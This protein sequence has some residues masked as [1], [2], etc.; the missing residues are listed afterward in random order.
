MDDLGSI[1]N[2]DFLK[3]KEKLL[4][5]FKMQ[6]GIDTPPEE[7]KKFLSLSQEKL[8]ELAT[9]EPVPEIFNCPTCNDGKRIRLTN[10]RKEPYFG[11]TF[12]CPECTPEDLLIRATGVDKAYSSWNLDQL[13]MDR[14]N[15]DDAIERLTAGDSLVMYG[16]V[17]RGK[18]HMAIGLLR[19]W[20]KLGGVTA[21]KYKPARFIYFPQFLDDMRELFGDSTSTQKAQQYETELAKYDLLVIDDLGAE[22]T[23]EWVIERI[24][25]LLDRRL[26]EGKQTM[27]TTNL[28]TLGEVGTRYG[29]R[30]A[31]RLGGYR[32]HECIGK[33]YRLV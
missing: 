23:S 25:V 16:K 4:L 18:T 15:I 10:N 29:A 6:Y 24:N 28:M 14:P 8:K 21:H 31:S 33:D 11:Q 13:E 12:P 2:P 9:A 20:I 5:A 7:E 27:I 17:G 22:R 3:A 26:R 32:W 19:E 1:D 30:T